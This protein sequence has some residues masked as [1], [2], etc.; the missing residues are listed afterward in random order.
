MEGT[1]QTVPYRIDCHLVA[2]KNI[3]LTGA[4]WVGKTW[5]S[6]GSACS[7]L[8]GVSVCEQER[9]CHCVLCVYGVML[10]LCVCVSL[11]D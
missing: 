5:A 9:E 8:G 2:I 3:L 10:T 7:N 6:F 1:V 11:I 4:A